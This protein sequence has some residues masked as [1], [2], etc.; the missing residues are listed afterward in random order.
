MQS[1]YLRSHGIRKEAE[2]GRQAK[3]KAKYLISLVVDFQM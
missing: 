2:D 1:R 3:L